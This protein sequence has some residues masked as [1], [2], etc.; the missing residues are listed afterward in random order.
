[1]LADILTG[2]IPAVPEQADRFARVPSWEL[3]ANDE[4]GT[5]GPTS[6]ANHRRLTTANLTGV[7]DAPTLAEVFDLYRRSGNPRFDPT[8]AWDDPRQ[9]DNGVYMQDMLEALL[10]DGIGGRKPVAFAK[11]AAGDMDTL[12]K[13]VAIFGGVLLGVNLNV[14]Q[15]RQAV[16]D[17]VAGSP[18]WGGHAVLAGRYADPVGDVNDRVGVVTWAYP[19]DATR[20]FVQHQE[21]ECWV[22]IWPE[23]LRDHAFLQGVD[24][25]ALAD[26]FKALTGRELPVPTEPPVEPPTDPVDPPVS[27]TDGP[28][29][30]HL[31]DALTRYLAGK[32]APAYLRSAA[33]AWMGRVT[34]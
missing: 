3:G 23:H 30:Q 17:T 22:V 26:A 18:E 16:W 25:A 29:A 12:D 9:D 28:E 34:R 33:T 32:S 8:L 21:D 10:A 14:A 13:A 15:Q 6:V 11:V 24:V 31:F 2:T 19:Q 20:A 7:M 27:P 4:F 5:C 1:M